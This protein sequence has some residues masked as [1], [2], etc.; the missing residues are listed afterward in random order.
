MGDTEECE[1]A[2]QLIDLLIARRQH[3]ATSIVACGEECTA[4][5]FNRHSSAL[6]DCGYQ[7]GKQK[8]QPRLTH[9]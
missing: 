9:R 7:Q 4:S 6:V 3:H 8:F 2:H 5:N 1:A